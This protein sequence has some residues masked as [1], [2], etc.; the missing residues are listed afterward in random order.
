M[1][2]R[3]Q[4]LSLWEGG[5]CSQVTFSTCSVMTFKTSTYIQIT[6]YSHSAT[7]PRHTAATTCIMSKD[8]TQF[9]VKSGNGWSC[10]K[11]KLWT[12]KELYPS[13]ELNLHDTLLKILL[14]RHYKTVTFFV[15]LGLL[16]NQGLG[17]YLL[18]LFY[19]FFP[20]SL[21]LSRYVHVRASAHGSLECWTSQELELQVWVLGTCFLWES[22][23]C[24]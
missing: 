7:M 13:L 18:M 9:R 21:S 11:G 8:G 1:E 24:S 14:I 12:M 22:R 19:K 20:P 10:F 16:A 23:M 5:A 17:H 6:I 4:L 15:Y 2:P 3:G